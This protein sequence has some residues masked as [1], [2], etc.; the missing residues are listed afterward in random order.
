LI[1]VWK[2]LGNGQFKNV[3]ENVFNVGEN[4]NIKPNG[5]TYQ[6][7]RVI[8]IDGDGSKELCYENLNCANLY[9]KYI[10]GKFI[11]YT[12][13]TSYN[14]NSLNFPTYSKH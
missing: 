4:I 11:K 1:I 9:Y 5:E 13:S 12:Q 10:N 3:T 2:N 7:I 6:K 14:F 8:D